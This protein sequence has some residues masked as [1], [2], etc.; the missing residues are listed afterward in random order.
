MKTLVKTFKN[1]VGAT[2]I[3]YGLIAALISVVII[4]SVQ[5]VGT[6][7]KDTFDK[8]NNSLVSNSST[9]SPA[10]ASTPAGH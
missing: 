1:K 8:V 5:N 9:T 3:E 10:P 6:N 4:S 2:A 7:V